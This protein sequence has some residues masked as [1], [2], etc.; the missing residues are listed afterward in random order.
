MECGLHSRLCPNI[1]AYP[2]GSCECRISKHCT[3]TLGYSE[4]QDP[5]HTTGTGNACLPCTVD[6]YFLQTFAWIN[7]KYKCCLKG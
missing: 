3:L 1:Y 6:V 4:V 5:T 7:T 2:E